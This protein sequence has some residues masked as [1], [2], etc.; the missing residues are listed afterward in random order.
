MRIVN[1]DELKG[2]GTD[3]NSVV[4]AL[5]AADE[6]PAP[7]VG[8]GCTELCWTDRRAY[9]VVEVKSPTCVMIQRDTVT[10]TDTHGMS[11]DQDYAYTPNPE[12]SRRT[13]RRNKAGQWKA[14]GD[15]K[16]ATYRMGLRDEHYDYSF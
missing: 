15:P 12:A 11:D 16:G 6:S 3:T 9:T 5:Y 10:R 8:M 4:N 1:L 2:L 7:E 14:Q 13:L